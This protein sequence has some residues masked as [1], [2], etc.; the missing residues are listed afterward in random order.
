MRA[1]FFKSGDLEGLKARITF[2]RIS[3]C[4]LLAL[5]VLRL[6]EL[7]IINY[8]KY[9]SLS[10]NNRIRNVIVNGP[11][12]I[13]YDRHKAVIVTNRPS[14]NLTLT[15]EDVQD[16]KFILS[17]CQ[18]RLDLTP[19]EIEKKI[20]FSY[21]E[22][23]IILKR[24]IAHADLAFIEEHK[25]DLP[26]IGLQIEPLRNY[27]YGPLASHVVGY[28]GE[29]NEKQLQVHKN[30]HT[31]FYRLGD[32]TGQ[33]GL[34]KELEGFLRGNKGERLVEVDS[35]GRE[36]KLLKKEVLRPSNNLV[37]TIDLELQRFIEDVFKDK[38][39]AVV[40]LN[41]NNGEVLALVSH[42]AFD[43]NLFSGGISQQNWVNL[44]SNRTK[45]LQNRVIQG[46]YSP[47]SVFKIIIAT[48]GLESGVITP[49]TRFY[50]P[51]YFPFGG[52]AFQCWRE[53]GHGSVD[54]HKAL[55][56]SCNVFF[57]NVG[58]RLGIDRIAKYA[59][60][61]GLGNPVGIG[62]TNEKG[63]IVP[64][65]I[66]KKEVLGQKWYPGETIS[67]SIGQGYI[68]VTPLQLATMISA[69]ANGGK[70]YKPLLVKRIESPDGRIIKEF[71]PQL[72]RTISLQPS[73]LAIIRKGLWGV[74]NAPGG[75][76]SKAQA[77]GIEA[78]GKTGTAQI[79]GL[80]KGGGEKGPEHLK[81]H[82]WFVAFAPVDHPQIAM[83]ILAEHSGKG[84]AAAAPFAGKVIEFYFKPRVIPAT[85]VEAKRE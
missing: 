84:G 67:V 53:R 4:L 80:S 27:I 28:V 34:E 18:N 76:G 1:K 33:Y 11:R 7:Q 60:L 46:Q 77:P 58:A 8:D 66:W 19:A 70:V 43:P 75:T 50:C 47:G 2:V 62:L 41:P 36:L 39:G 12:G 52:R 20:K 51:G 23:D 26:G 42:P 73:T 10:E 5:I 15:P 35:L 25:L 49:A 82:A 9:K 37:L 22:K 17:L 85:Q 44:I 59:S 63:G 65:N 56:E 78:A 64:S 21:L 79:V 14:F 69:V 54:I 57:Y 31:S 16:L 55:V 74:V 83:A 48:A 71:N 24:D 40:V 81:T 61:Y 38:S 6:W 30:S 72:I 32:L 68:S 3:F 45:P 29:I 13:I